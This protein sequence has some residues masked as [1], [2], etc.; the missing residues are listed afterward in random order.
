MNPDAT[1]MNP[2]SWSM[3]LWEKDVQ[4]LNLSGTAP[5]DPTTNPKMP[6]SSLDTLTDAMSDTLMT[7]FFQGFFAGLAVGVVLTLSVKG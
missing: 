3:N 6:P 7:T 4:R 1:P 5:L 2:T